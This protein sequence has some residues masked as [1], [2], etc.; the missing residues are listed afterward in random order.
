MRGE[1]IYSLESILLEKH[2][3]NITAENLLSVRN[4]RLNSVSPQTFRHELGMLNRAVKFHIEELGN[5]SLP[6]L[7]EINIPALNASQREAVSKA[8]Y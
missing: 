2:P 7:P 6:Y 1:L 5:D 4:G 3:S 8:R